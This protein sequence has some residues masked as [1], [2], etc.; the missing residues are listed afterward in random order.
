MNATCTS[1]NSG[2]RALSMGLDC[3]RTLMIGLLAPQS[4]GSDADAQL[5]CQFKTHQ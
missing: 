3:F 2:N 1:T 4:L 5:V